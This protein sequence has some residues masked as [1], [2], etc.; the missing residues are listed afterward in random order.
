MNAELLNKRVADVDLTVGELFAIFQEIMQEQQQQKVNLPTVD[1]A[2]N[3]KPTTLGIP[4]L[5]MGVPL[6]PLPISCED[7][8]GSDRIE[9]LV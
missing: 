1:Q 2:S 5:D 8:Y 7:M 3:T 4:S 9:S 6:R